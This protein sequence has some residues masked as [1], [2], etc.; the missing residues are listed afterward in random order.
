MRI[1]V[2]PTSFR[3]GPHAEDALLIGCKE[4]PYSVPV[5]VRRFLEDTS[6][7]LKHAGRKSGNVRAG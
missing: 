1:I 7:G 4:L 3:G 2:R 5:T 6:R